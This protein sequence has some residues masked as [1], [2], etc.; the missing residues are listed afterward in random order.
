MHKHYILHCRGVVPGCARHL[1]PY[2]AG[3][4][5]RR[6]TSVV[7]CPDGIRAAIT[8]KEGRVAEKSR[9]PVQCGSFDLCSFAA[10]D[11]WKQSKRGKLGEILFPVRV[12]RACASFRSPER[13]LVLHAHRHQ[14][15]SYSPHEPAINKLR[16]RFTRLVTPLG[17]PPPR[18]VYRT[19]RDNIIR[20][21]PTL[22]GVREWGTPVV[23][24]LSCVFKGSP[25]LGGTIVH[26]LVFRFESC[27]FSS[28]RERR[29]FR[30]HYT[31]R[32]EH[33]RVMSRTSFPSPPRPLDRLKSMLP[34]RSY[35]FQLP[36]CRIFL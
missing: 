20:S 13:C 15:H 11:F 14:F 26:V 30:D 29:R 17:L 23:R 32:N 2:R 5:S 35:P 10:R 21:C 34:S 24:L 1:C 27:L 22:L 19:R 18:S 9:E 25:V 12:P 16:F 8:L 7:T 4:A 3:Q 28:I 6:N 33:E 31:S 36:S